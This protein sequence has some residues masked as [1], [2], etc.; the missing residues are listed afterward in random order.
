MQ[1]A[2]QNKKEEWKVRQAL[3]SGELAAM[4]KAI[5]ILHSDDSRDLFKKSFSSQD[6]TFLFL[7]ESMTTQAIRKT[8]AIKESE[9]RKG[10]CFER[11][12]EIRL[13]FF[14]PVERCQVFLHL[15]ALTRDF[16]EI[17]KGVARLTELG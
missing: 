10:G 16:S 4:S 12:G 2:L 14:S 9:H 17:M 3:R 8:A 1:S 5:S 11:D 13:M 6:K 15:G 7:Q